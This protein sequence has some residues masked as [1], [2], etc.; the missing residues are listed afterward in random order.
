MNVLLQLTIRNLMLN[1]KRTIVTIIGVILSGAMICG[2][3]ALAASFQDVFIRSAKVTDGGHHVTFYEVPYED[4]K[5]IVSHV[6]TETSMFS[7]DIGY[8]LLEQSANLP[9]LMI[10]G[11]DAAAFEHMPVRLKEGRFPEKPGEIVLSESVFYHG[12]VELHPGD[13]LTLQIGRR[14]ADGEVIDHLPLSDGE[15]LDVFATRVFTVTGII[16]KPSFEM[17]EAGYGAVAY[18]SEDSLQPQEKVNVSVILKK[19]KQVFE[20]APQMAETAGIAEWNISYNRELLKWMGITSNDRVNEMFFTAS[21]IVSLLIVIGSV[22]VIYNAFA[23]SVSERKKQFG[24][25]SSVGATGRQIRRIVFYEAFLLGI[26]GIPI[27]IL[28]GYAGIGVTIQIINQI[29]KNSLFSLIEE[30]RLVIL[31]ET[32][33]IS[34]FFLA[35]TIFIS[36]YLPAK[37]AARISPVEAIRQTTD[38]KLERKHV[39]TMRW[40]RRVFGIEGELALKNLKRN[41]RRYRATVFSLFIS[42]VLYVSFSSF[43]NYGLASGGLYFADVPYDYLVVKEE[44]P[45]ED[46]IRLYKEVM[47]LKEVEQGAIV[48]SFHLTAKNLALTQFGSYIRNEVIRSEEHP[49]RDAFDDPDGGY[50]IG[51][52]I[53]TL[54]DEAFAQYAAEL[55]LNKQDFENTEQPAGILIN[56][57]KVDYP[58]YAEYEPLNAEAGQRLTLFDMPYDEEG[59]PI[60]FEVV[61]G[62]VADDIHFAS[63][64]AGLTGVNMI[65]SDQV[66]AHL[67][68][69]LHEQSRE[70][71]EHA[72]LV[73]QVA[74]ETNH[75]SFMEQ[76]KVLDARLFPGPYLNIVEMNE[77]GKEMERSKTII[78]IF[79]YG[80]ISLITLIGVTNIFNTISTNI[81]LR[82]REFAMLKSVGLTPAGFNK[83]MN[84]ESIFYGLKALLYGLP[85]GILLSVWMYNTINRVFQFTFMLPWKEIAVC[86][87]AVFMIVFITM[88]HSSRKLKKENIIHAL[89]D[90][91]F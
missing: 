8:A 1:R 14:V 81:A 82:R 26:I 18:L 34:V 3:A 33:L 2:A 62:A 84:Y 72:Q 63:G 90:E 86:V 40:T 15:S 38:I 49:M 31:P 36:A 88:L 70:M 48:R 43:I 54:G 80:F 73:L 59:S 91:N 28:S 32:I 9:Y 61:V 16:E 47:E 22:T 41:R 56:K 20:L 79:L 83:M 13:A 87:I 67:L 85:A 11:Y 65:V 77:L 35:L 51:V 25:L 50:Q 75:V 5:Y 6:N 19:P 58:A 4:S 57:N 78:S 69:Q 27:G 24:M 53:M 52:N 71:A 66:F 76:I 74:E 60:S 42:I 23:I 44:L 37:R 17:G 12:G 45:A 68:P 29:N 55:G 21:M 30:M 89:K 46:R 64:F 39:R 7:K 10:K